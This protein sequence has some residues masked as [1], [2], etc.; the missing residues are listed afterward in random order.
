MKI[1]I[2]IPALN[3][4]ALLPGC[5]C[6]VNAARSC[7]ADVASE[8]IVCD[9]NS[10]DRTGELAVAGGA[11]VTIESFQ[12]TAAAARNRG[13]TLAQ[14]DWLLFLDADSRPTPE[15]FAA[16]LAAM[17]SGRYHAGTSTLRTAR[18]DFGLQLWN[19]L[20]VRRRRL[21][22]A[23]VFHAKR[24]H[25]SRGTIPGNHEQD[26]ARSGR[27]P[28][29]QNPVSPGV[30]DAGRAEPFRDSRGEDLPGGQVRAHTGRTHAFDA[31]QA[32][33][34]ARFGRAGFHHCQPFAGPSK[35]GGETDA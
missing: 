10:T 19:A 27:S 2:I 29:G 30:V 3:E 33:N 31:R 23:E 25:D 8:V 5:L 14:G 35:T 32:N 12:R 7:F 9:N 28:D 15:L 17:Q 11:R 1:S 18:P 6:A 26:S 34:G 24:G 20:S 21:A 22:G 13:A 16:V 4:E